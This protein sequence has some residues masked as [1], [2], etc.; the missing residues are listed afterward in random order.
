MEELT[1][2]AR[3]VLP[4]DFFTRKHLE[5]VIQELNFNASPGVP[6][7]YTDSTLKKMFDWD[8]ISFDQLAV[9]RIWNEI[10]AWVA[11]ELDANPIRVFIKEE[12]HKKDKIDQGRL[13]LISS[14]AIREQLVDH[15]LL[16]M[17]NEAEIGN[18][19]R[20]PFK[21]GMQFNCGGLH[22]FV[23]K[24][25]V[26][27][28]DKSLWDWTVG[29]VVDLDLEY[30]ERMCMDQY[31]NKDQY[32]LWRS[33]LRRRYRELY[34]QPVFQLSSGLQFRQLRPG[35]VKSGAV[36]TIS[37]NSHLQLIYHLIAWR[38]EFG[39]ERA[40]K[41]MCL[42]DD[43]AVFW[44]DDRDPSGYLKQTGDLGCKIKIAQL[45]YGRYSF[46]GHIITDVVIPEYNGKHLCRL[47]YAEDDILLEVLDS[48]QRLYALDD[49]RLALIHKWLVN[50]D[51]ERVI[52]PSNL[53]N[54]Y[55]GYELKNSRPEY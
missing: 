29:D 9:D 19:Q 30:R 6:Y 26:L 20:L 25:R 38:R 34:Y 39:E 3:F 35:L 11:G 27:A 10:Q 33:L 46:A 42:G 41:I 53:K 28:C 5:R 36:N 16:D 23:R 54:W 18:W 17:Q 21:P 31:F 13:R 24:S 51:M 12:P 50:L 47:I 7:L 49:P 2:E 37:I 8:G 32:D 43:T 4:S 55:L 15:M 40:P 14:V 48:Y 22:H 44:P 1:P 52:S 45:E